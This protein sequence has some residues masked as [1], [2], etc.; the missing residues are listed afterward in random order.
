MH[1]QPIQ[2]RPFGVVYLSTTFLLLS[3]SCFAHPIRL[4]PKILGLLTVAVTILVLWWLAPAVFPAELE[5][6][7]CLRDVTRRIGEH[8][9]DPYEHPDAFR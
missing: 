9:H 6:R 5:G 2:P 4:A 1:F 8:D 3:T 7:T